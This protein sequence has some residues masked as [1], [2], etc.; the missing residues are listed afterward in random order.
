MIQL[1]EVRVTEA[2]SSIT[3][4]LRRIGFRYNSSDVVDYNFLM[5][6]VHHKLFLKLRMGCEKRVGDILVF[7]YKPNNTS[8]PNIITEEGSIKTNRLTDPNIYC[9]VFET[10]DL[11][12][13][14]LKECVVYNKD[15]YFGNH[16][17][18][19]IKGS[20]SAVEQ[21]QNSTATTDHYI[22]RLNT[23]E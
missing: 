18:I 10:P 16:S 4:A 19:S 1:K 2:D 17:W 6:Q 22:L 9:M 15:I 23:T 8:L 7:E 14:I 21:F 3:Y 20:E 12:S 11:V 13:G 5:K